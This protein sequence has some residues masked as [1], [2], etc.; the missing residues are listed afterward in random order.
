[1]KTLKTLIIVA[2]A[3][4]LFVFS[5]CNKDDDEPNKKEM[6]TA[7]SWKV[8]AFTLDSLGFPILDIYQLMDDCNKD[9]LTI[10]NEDG[11]YES[12]EG[13]TKCN[14]A[15]PQVI[16]EGTWTFNSDETQ[17]ITTSDTTQTMDIVTL[18]SSKLA[19]SYT[20]E[21]EGVVYTYSIEMAPGN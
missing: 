8:T 21:E 18:N 5:S 17:I 3:T 20:E 11:T 19:I 1:M 6:L 2:I 7:N 13:P 12:N 14:D 15:D 4:S 10:F 9:D 16:E